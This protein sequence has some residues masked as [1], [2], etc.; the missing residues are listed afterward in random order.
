MAAA[1]KAHGAQAWAPGRP[2]RDGS[3]GVFHGQLDE[4]AIWNQSLRADQI[5]NLSASRR[6]LPLEVSERRPV[7]FWT[8]DD[9][10]SGGIASG[11]NSIIDFSGHGN[12]ATP[13][14]GPETR[15][16]QTLSYP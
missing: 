15:G 6:Y 7:V 2:V 4:V 3:G 8:L 10:P 5:R 13:F 14:N 9:G 16:S 11:T 1:I 12:H